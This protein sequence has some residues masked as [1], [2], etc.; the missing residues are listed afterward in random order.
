MRLAHS[1]HPKGWGGEEWLVNN[2][3]YC[4]KIL[5]VDAARKC[6]IH[7]HRVKTETF[8]VLTGKVLL[9]VGRELG[10]LEEIE[11]EENDSFHVPPGLLHQFE[12][13]LDSKV[14]EVSTQHFEEDSI[15][16]VPGD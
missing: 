16:L 13:V 9:R 3:L 1:W 4:A 2:N 11:L 7:F 5:S 14:L 15:R 6:S 10:S 12:A 8:T